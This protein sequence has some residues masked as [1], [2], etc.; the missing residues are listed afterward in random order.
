MVGKKYRVLFTRYA[1]RRRQ[2]INDFEENLNGKH[3]A[4][5]IQRTI[6]R[7][8]Q[9]LEKLPEAHPIYEYHDSDYEVRYTKALDYKILFRVLKKVGEVIILTIRNDAENPNKIRDEV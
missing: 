3:C 7:E 6:D 1:Q 2:Q 9:K 5:K 8:S 4:L